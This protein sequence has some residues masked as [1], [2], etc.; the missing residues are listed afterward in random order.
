MSQSHYA[1]NAV[2]R[3]TGLTAHVIRIWEKRYEA[4]RPERTASNRRLYSDEQVQ[5]LELLRDATKA[6]QSISVVAKLP[7][8]EL[9]RMAAAAAVSGAPAALKQA[10]P[11]EA[12]AL[13]EAALD[14]VRALDARGLEQVLR[15]ADVILGTQGMLQRV[16][17]PLAQAL[18]SHWRDGMITAAHEHFATVVLRTYLA[19][20]AQI[21]AASGNEPVLVV[22]TPPGQLHELGA[23]LV[24]ASAGNLGWRVVYLGVSLPA[25]EIAGAALQSRA[26]AVALSLVYPDNDTR[27]EGELV[28]LRE[29]LP[30]GTGLIAGGRAIAAYRPILDKIGAVQVQDLPRLLSALDDFRK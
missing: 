16:A 22:A 9:R 7:T 3:R 1:I 19:T 6:G 21:F 12:S 17:A 23:M 25:A 30:A 26:K 11:D 4:V 18:G 20:A 10:P 29:L 13:F 24:A 2:V 5:R 14:A 8:D 28:R 27:L 15:R